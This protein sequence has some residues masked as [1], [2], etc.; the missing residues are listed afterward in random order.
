MS[1]ACPFQPESTTMPQKAITLLFRAIEQMEA[2][3][4]TPRSTL[5]SAKP[6]AARQR[7]RNPASANPLR[8]L[9]PKPAPQAKPSAKAAS[10][11]K[12]KGSNARA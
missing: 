9:G 10:P 11:Q 3:D 7:R 12:R 8:T 4:R 6:A 1:A 5:K 2:A